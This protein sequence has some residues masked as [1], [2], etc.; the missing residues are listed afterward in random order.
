MERS[1]SPADSRREL[2]STVVDRGP[3]TV[4]ARA[5]RS[6]LV[7]SVVDSE[8]ST[9]ARAASRV[10]AARAALERLGEVLDRRTA[11]AGYALAACAVYGLES[12][13]W[14]LQGGRDSTTYLMYFL[15]MWHAHPA[16]PMLMLFR[17]PLAPLLMGVPLRLGGAALLEVVFG[18]MYVLSLVAYTLAAR[19]FGRACAILT[20]V[21]LL[22][23]P[24]Y[25]ALFHQAASD[26]VFAFVLALWTL[27]AVRAAE[28][29]S[30]MRY[31]LLGLAF[32]ALVLAR[33]SSQ[34]FLLFAVVPL[35]LPGRWRARAVRAGAF[36]GVALVALAVW[37]GYNDLRYGDFTVSRSGNADVPF[38]RVFV[39][40]KDVRPENGPA[41]REL[42]AAVRRDVLPVYAKLGGRMDVQTF[43][44][45]ASD[46]M[47][48]DLVVVS[49][50]RFGW[51]SNYAILR[52][53]AI[54]TIEKHPGLYVDDV[55]TAMK[56]ELVGRYAFAAPRVA[57]PAAA[58]KPAAAPV[59]RTVDRSDPGGI[60]WWLATTPD[61]H[62]RRGENGLVWSTRGG[63][64]HAAWLN[65]AA[66]RLQSDL[67]N[68]NGS[69]TVANALNE[70]SR[71]YPRIVVWLLAGVLA[72]ALRRPRRWRLP[73]AL[74]A[75]GLVA[76]LATIA[77]MPPGLEYRLPFDPLF[78]L[79]AI[80]MLTIPAR[81]R[82]VR[83]AA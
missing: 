15:D 31:A 12:I 2:S 40:E 76:L 1:P 72:L 13:A 4:G 23:H 21:A 16:Y 19:T 3:H 25:G 44:K 10:P 6:P 59:V 79:F 8:R 45:T 33:P 43:F 51:S 63:Q 17:T 68:R 57:Q 71:Y 55:A 66:V 46:R 80:A 75:L 82:R 69:P 54:E 60:V 49:D 37:A 28:R 83:A 9:A 5:R 81:S 52:K 39:L 20:A 35:L 47:W 77:G 70:L 14:P 58:T 29:P 7:M 48:G 67:P 22:A 30:T 74:A 26:S 32:L 56:T 53:V 11:V 65:R 61:G 36:L 50:R 64:A 24:A 34:V 42:A 38:Y 18:V 41:S 73:T 62:I 78:L 27:A